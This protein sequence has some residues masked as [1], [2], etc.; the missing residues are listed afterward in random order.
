MELLRQA[1]TELA[2]AKER[3]YL[4]EEADRE[5]IATAAIFERQGNRNP[6]IDHPGVGVADRVRRGAL[7]PQRLEV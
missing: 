7:A 4:D 3:E 2:A 1:L 6:L 5:A